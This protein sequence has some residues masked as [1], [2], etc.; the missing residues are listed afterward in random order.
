MFK[1][2]EHADGTLSFPDLD[3]SNESLNKVWMWIEPT[4][5]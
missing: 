2:I 1:V 5:T 4:S 3:Y